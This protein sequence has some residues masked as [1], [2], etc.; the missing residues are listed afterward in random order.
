MGKAYIILF[1]ALLLLSNICLFSQSPDTASTHTNEQ[2]EEFDEN[3]W[4]DVTEGLDYNEKLEK[5]K[6][7]EESMNT[8]PN[9]MA[10]LFSIV[11]LILFLGLIVLMVYLILRLAGVKIDKSISGKK[12]IKGYSLSQIEENLLDADLEHALKEAI[13]NRQY[14]LAI[15]L[16][17][18]III[19]KLALEKLIHWNRDKT[20]LHYIMEL[21]GN[22]NAGKF[23]ELT[24]LF[25]NVWYG[26]INLNEETFQNINGGFEQFINSIHKNVKRN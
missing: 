23:R 19:Q 24:H 10:I 25:E 26:D 12:K 16:Y 8:S 20:N 11:K 3:K 6:K 15:R 21:S 9:F 22:Q 17:Y 7:T 2:L 18:L 5:K 1:G 14:K 13:Q 4:K